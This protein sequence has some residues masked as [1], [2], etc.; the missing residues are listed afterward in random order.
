MGARVLV[1]ALDAAVKKVAV[2]GGEAV[3]K[4]VVS[5]VLVPPAD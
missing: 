4:V 2:A 3:E 5:E 1:D